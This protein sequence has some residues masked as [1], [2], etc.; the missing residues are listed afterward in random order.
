MLQADPPSVDK[1]PE[2][3]VLGVTVVLVT[4]SYMEREFVRVGYYVNNEY[5][6]EYEE[7][8]GPPPLSKMDMKLV[9]RQILSDK[10]RVTKFPISWGK[11]ELQQSEQ[12]MD[13]NADVSMMTGGPK[14]AF[15]AGTASTSQAIAMDTE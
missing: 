7:E 2:E 4:C 3:D 13:T 12:P 6:G 15:E 8:T 9:Q 11:E 1:L 14:L 5:V 10:P